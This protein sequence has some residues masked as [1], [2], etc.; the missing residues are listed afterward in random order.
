MPIAMRPGRAHTAE[1]TLFAAAVALLACVPSQIPAPSRGPTPSRLAMA[2]LEPTPSLDGTWV[3]ARYESPHPLRG[4]MG[5]APLLAMSV[6]F[7]LRGTQVTLGSALDASRDVGGASGAR[8]A[9][10]DRVGTSIALAATP[11][12]DFSWLFD[13]GRGCVGPD[14]LVWETPGARLT[15]VR[16][17]AVPRPTTLCTS[18]DARVFELRARCHADE[19]RT[20]T[21]QPLAANSCSGSEASQ[22]ARELER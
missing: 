11:G 8:L 4:E 12:S 20:V 3:I 2:R 18:R 22:D 21:R 19:R 13:R 17:T 14:R 15:M 16:A 5:I 6:T 1:L 9:T 7:E 10:I